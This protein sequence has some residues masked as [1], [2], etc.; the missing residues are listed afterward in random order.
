M[1]FKSTEHFSGIYF[2]VVSFRITCHHKKFDAIAR[3]ESLNAHIV[4]QCFKL[5]TGAMETDHVCLRHELNNALIKRL[6]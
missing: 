5:V 3:K 6:F 1:N 2:N 4:K